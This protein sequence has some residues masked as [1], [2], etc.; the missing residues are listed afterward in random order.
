M[1]AAHQLRMEGDTPEARHARLETIRA[2]QQLRREAEIPEAIQARLETRP[3]QVM[4]FFLPIMLS[5]IAPKF[6]LLCF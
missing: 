4:P 2:A 1:R 6:S 3:R 5:G